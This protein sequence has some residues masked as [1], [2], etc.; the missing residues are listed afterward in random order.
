LANYKQDKLFVVEECDISHVS[1]QSDSKK[2]DSSYK[3]SPEFLTTCMNG[4]GWIGSFCPA[5]SLMTQQNK[6]S[7]N[8]LLQDPYRLVC[9]C[10][11]FLW[12]CVLSCELS[13]SHAWSYDSEVQGNF[14]AS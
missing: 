2:R 10:L 5:S 12:S 8:C 9:E 1:C 13:L 4:L 7:H 3:L 14:I 11:V 6:L